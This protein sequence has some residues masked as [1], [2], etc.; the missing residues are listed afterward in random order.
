MG[1]WM[2]AMAWGL[3]QPWLHGRGKPSPDDDPADDCYEA[4]SYL[5]GAMGELVPAKG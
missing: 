2:T 5:M 1:T 4:P 3:P